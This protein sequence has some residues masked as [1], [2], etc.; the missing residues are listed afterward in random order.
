MQAEL[1]GAVPKL[2]FAFTKTL[3]NRAWRLIRESHLWSFNVFESSWTSPSPISAGTASVTQ[4]TN[5]V[6]FDATA[7]AALNVASTLIS[8]VTQRQFRVGVGGIYNIISYVPA[9]GLATLD[10]IFGDPTNSAALY[11][12]YQVYYTPPF[13]DHLA[14]FSVRNPQMFLDLDLDKTRAW[15]DKRDP[16]RSWYQ[17]PTHVVPF[18]TDMRGAGTTNASA[19]LG[20][21]LFELWG[22]P[23]VP[24]TYQCYGLRRGVDLVRP[25]DVL[26]ISVGE[27]LVLARAKVWA[28]E[29]AEANK[30]VAPRATGPDFRFL[31]GM[32]RDEYREYLTLYRKQDKEIIDNY[33]SAREPGLAS[34]AYGYYNTLASVAGPYAQV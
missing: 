27:D 9:T 5:T 12:V 22:Q 21:P 29:W 19:T 14:W 18:G 16:Q 28:Y 15:V 1:R 24:F 20:F 17:F 34:R 25:D 33:F 31:M 3:I 7:T 6:Q 11:T 30:D 32:A 8:P 26:P 2:P 4:G 10:R 13:L 23:V